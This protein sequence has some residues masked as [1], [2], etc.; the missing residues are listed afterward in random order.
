MNLQINPSSVS[1][2]AFGKTKNFKL[3]ALKPATGGKHYICKIG[4]FACF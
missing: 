3:A 4:A 2:K 1:L